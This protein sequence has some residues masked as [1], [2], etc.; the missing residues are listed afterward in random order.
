[1]QYRWWRL[2]GHSD[3]KTVLNL[4]ATKYQMIKTLT[5][6]TIDWTHSSTSRE[7]TT[8]IRVHLKSIH[9]LRMA[10]KRAIEAHKCSWAR[11]LKRIFSH[12]T[13]YSSQH[14]YSCHHTWWCLLHRLRICHPENSM[15]SRYKSVQGSSV[16]LIHFRTC[17]LTRPNKQVDNCKPC[18]I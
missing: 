8:W 14:P 10:I 4:A 9:T 18:T 13:L 17:Y 6:L 3:W 11:N 1:M 2:S 5:L 16:K 7:A 15:K 12:Y